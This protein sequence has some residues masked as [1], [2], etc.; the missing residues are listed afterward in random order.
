MKREGGDLV[1]SSEVVGSRVVD[2][3]EE[4]KGRRV[5]DQFGFFGGAGC[6]SIAER[7]IWWCL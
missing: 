5:S 2:D 3:G 1:V 7:E 6:C 4:K